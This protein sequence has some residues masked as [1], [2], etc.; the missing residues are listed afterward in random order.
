MLSCEVLVELEHITN[1]QFIVVCLFLCADCPFESGLLSH[2]LASTGLNEACKSIGQDTP[3]ERFDVETFPKLDTFITQL[4]IPKEFPTNLAMI[5][6]EMSVEQYRLTINRGKCKATSILSLG[7]HLGI[8]KELLEVPQV[9]ADM[10]HI[11]NI[12]HQ[13]GTDTGPPVAR[14]VRQSAFFKERQWNP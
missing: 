4:A 13:G 11:L 1:Q 9:R 2:I 10:Y 5:S 7:R 6:T 3:F 12:T 8:Y 14:G